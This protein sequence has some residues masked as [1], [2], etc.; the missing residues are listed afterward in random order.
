MEPDHWKGSLKTNFRRR[1]GPGLWVDRRWPWIQTKG[2]PPLVA[3]LVGDVLR[4]VGTCQLT[5]PPWSWRSL[6]NIVSS[7]W[8]L[9]WVINGGKKKTITRK[10]NNSIYYYFLY[11]YLFLAVL[12]LRCYSGFSLVSESGGY[13]AVAVHRIHVAGFSHCR[14]QA[15]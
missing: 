11:F 13:S 8:P 6:F 14:A 5:H 15:Q 1:L 7:L 9:N 2:S 10:P 12:G 3:S 4:G